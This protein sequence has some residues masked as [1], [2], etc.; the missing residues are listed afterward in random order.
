M[1]IPEKILCWNGLASSW[2]ADKS[3]PRLLFKICEHVL[4]ESSRRLSSGQIFS[5]NI[6]SW[7]VCQGK[8]RV[9]SRR[10]I[11]QI[12]FLLDLFSQSPLANLP[13]N[14]LRLMTQKSAMF[15]SQHRLADFPQF[16][17]RVVFLI[18]A[19]PISQLLLADF[20]QFVLRLLIASS[21]SHNLI[22]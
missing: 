21:F 1:W 7:E 9:C 4:A 20:L 17:L 10:T 6:L 14:A 15:H 13:Q 22:S 2:A 5:Q 12:F 19:S 18:S 3:N 11:S 16:G 8:L